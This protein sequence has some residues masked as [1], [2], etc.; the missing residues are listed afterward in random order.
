MLLEILSTIEYFNW[1]FLTFLVTASLFYI[2]IHV[3][4]ILIPSFLDGF[5]DNKK[6]HTLIQYS[7]VPIFR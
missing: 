2:T 6:A 4:Q 1:Q 5:G 7:P 3:L